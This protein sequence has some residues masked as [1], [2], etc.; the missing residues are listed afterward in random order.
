MKCQ[1]CQTECR[2]GDRFCD[3]CG[4]KLPERKIETAPQTENTQQF[5]A[6]T[7]PS[8][9][10]EVAAQP[11][12]TAPVVP[13]YAAPVAEPAPVAPTAPVDE[14]AAREESVSSAMSYLDELLAKSTAQEEVQQEAAPQTAVPFVAAAA[15]ATA[16]AFSADEN[17][18]PAYEAPVVDPAYEMPKTEEPTFTAPWTNE[19]AE[20]AQAENKANEETAQ[21]SDVPP[22]MQT[23]LE[24]TNADGKKSEPLSTGKFML[25]ELLRRIPVLGGIVALVLYLVWAFSSDTNENLKN[26]SRSQ[27]IWIL[28][29]LA[30]VILLVVILVWVIGAYAADIESILRQYN[31]NINAI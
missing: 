17:T 12:Y 31:F 27:L 9:F 19:Q 8:F 28:I 18:T 23:T 29:S 26:Y 6:D 13:V 25:L 7:T 11:A 3:V 4:T 21:T 22:V 10:E 30:L 15:T 14:S 1:Y 2:E 16:V 5:F 24:P 20:S